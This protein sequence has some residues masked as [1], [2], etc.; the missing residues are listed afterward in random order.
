MKLGLVKSNFIE[1]EGMLHCGGSKYMHICVARMRGNL[2]KCP[3]SKGYLGDPKG[4]RTLALCCVCQED[5]QW[6]VRESKGRVCVNGL[7]YFECTRE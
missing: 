3:P 2:E 5:R 1:N 6:R 4:L 7:K